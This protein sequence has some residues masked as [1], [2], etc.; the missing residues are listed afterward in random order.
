MQL[1]T[2]LNLGSAIFGSISAYFWFMA[3]AVKFPKELNG[4]AVDPHVIIKTDD[5]STAILDSAKKNKYA[6][7]CSGISITCL[8]IPILIDIFCNRNS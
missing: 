5:L 2:Y 1:S 8:T 7:I 4:V 6:A 3:A